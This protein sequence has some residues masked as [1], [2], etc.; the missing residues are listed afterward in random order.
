[1]AKGRE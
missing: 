1:V